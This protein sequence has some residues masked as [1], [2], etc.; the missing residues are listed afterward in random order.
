[1]Q[2]KSLDPINIALNGTKLIEAS[3]GT[4][5]TYAITGLYIRLVVEKELDVDK[6]LVVTFTEAATRE[7]RDRIR[8]RLLDALAAYENGS[9]DDEFLVGLVQKHTS[10]GRD[11]DKCRK[12]LALALHSID[13]AAI[14][15]IHGFC[16]RVLQDCAFESGVLFDFDFS[17]DDSELLGQI[18]DD[19]WRKNADLWH[20]AFGCYLYSKKVNAD[21][22]FSFLQK[23]V[24]ICRATGIQVVELPPTISPEDVDP[25]LDLLKS[26]W[27]QE[28][29]IIAT[30]LQSPALSKAKSSYSAANIAK[31]LKSI[32]E[33]FDTHGMALPFDAFDRMSSSSLLKGTKPSKAGE[34]PEHQFFQLAD[35]LIGQCE[36]AYSGLILELIKYCLS[37]LPVRK[38]VSG[39]LSFDDL[40][41]GVRDAVAHPETGKGLAAKISNQY[42]A[43]LIDEFQ[44]T[45]AVQYEIFARVYEKGPSVLFLIGDPKQAIY[46]FRGADIFAYLRAVKAVGQ[47]IYGLDTNWRSQANM[48]KAFNLLF[49]NHPIARPFF[50]PEI[51]YQ[52]VKAPNRP[53]TVFVVDG[54]QPASMSFLLFPEQSKRAE[55]KKVVALDLAG[56]ISGLIKLGEKG[57]AGYLSDCAGNQDRD[58]ALAGGAETIEAIKAGDIAVLVRSHTDGELIRD[59]LYFQG[60][61]AVIHSRQDVFLTPEARELE[62]V[63]AAILTP[64][65]GNR[66]RAALT[67]SLLGW[68]SDKLVELEEDE[69]AWEDVLERFHEYQRLWSVKSFSVM[70]VT[71]FRNEGVSVRVAE[72]IE[73]ERRLTNLR[74]ITE[75]LQDK[76]H[77]E[78][79]GPLALFDLLKKYRHDNEG[80]EERQLRLDSDESLV[81]IVTIHKSKGLEYPVVFC[82]FLWDSSFLRNTK[83]GWV[84]WHDDGGNERLD[85]GTSQL[86]SKRIVH[87]KETLAEEL[88]LLYV[89][90]TRARNRCYIYWGKALS[91]RRYATASS[92]LNYL[93]HPPESYKDSPVKALESC[94][95]SL[96]DDEVFAPLYK[97]AAISPEAVKVSKI[98]M[99]GWGIKARQED[100]LRLASVPLFDRILEAKWA[101]RSFSG[102]QRH[103]SNAIEEPDH[104][105]LVVEISNDSSLGGLSEEKNTP[106]ADP[107]MF[108]FPRGAQAGNCL[109]NIFEK[110]DFVSADQEEMLQI[111]ESAL[112]DFGISDEWT[113]VVLRGLD[114][115]LA[116]P[117]DSIY[118][119]LSLKALSMEQRLME[120][121]FYYSLPMFSDKELNAIFR[122]H[123]GLPDATSGNLS[124]KQDEIGFM[125]GFID[126]IFEWQGK[127][128]I[129]D[130]KS[131]HLGD[132]IE[133]YNQ[134]RLR[135]EMGKSG[136]DLQYHIYLVALHR[137][138]RNRLPYY[139]YDTHIGGVYYLFLRGMSPEKGSDYGVFA[140]LPSR[141]VVEGIDRMLQVAGGDAVDL[142]IIR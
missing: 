138:L 78:R 141:Q 132:K 75:I 116:T 105:A 101:V 133:D 36:K 27:L 32:D 8:G 15:T 65:D 98:D 89:A 44:D 54:N 4:G 113:G 55:A 123:I 77:G 56:R 50:I 48:I 1:M 91:G 45:D 140:D 80:G 67:T 41:I 37:E 106:V 112:N 35:D 49:G 120:L 58:G 38:N 90:V 135:E 130:Y 42:Q 9:S 76:A 29:E 134:T 102:L 115:I 57:R 66:L 21:T 96:K 14:Y 72:F 5:K 43:V 28:K 125:K 85:L 69:R 103:D 62:I 22:L 61:R 10:E 74:H 79:L 64:T 127:Y 25:D 59:A 60:V 7:L 107:T 139:D 47:E 118:N 17:E 2:P 23:P 121:E 86:D 110:V 100:T 126:L 114:S 18:I 3:A 46:R 16:M 11:L 84:S 99:T 81:K 137:Y 109:H 82:P 93:L 19:Y 63:L 6:I 13:L 51:H 39:L 31:W 12:R 142:T 117:L 70:A 87:E 104:D 119:G 30:L 131:N 94:F 97:M 122:S 68:S 33:Y 40:L 92:G 73:G 128:F 111:V 83:D 52:D 95:K 53:E 108:D 26:V 20:D 129:L 136:Y 124:K 24:S 71:L 88:R 34:T